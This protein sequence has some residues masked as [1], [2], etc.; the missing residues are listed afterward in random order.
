M[1]QPRARTTFM[2]AFTSLHESTDGCAAVRFRHRLL[3]LLITFIL[4]TA[5]P[6]GDARRGIP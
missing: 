6:A 3:L 4:V 2:T 1:A 5:E